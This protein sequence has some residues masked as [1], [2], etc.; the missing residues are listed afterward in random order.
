MSWRVNALVDIRYG[1]S[2]FLVALAP[3]KIRYAVPNFARRNQV[4][5]PT[6][7]PRNVGCFY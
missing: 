7:R 5:Q 6:Q 4:G 2:G 1:R 3:R